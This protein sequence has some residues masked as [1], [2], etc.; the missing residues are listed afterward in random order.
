M[1]VGSSFS[2]SSPLALSHGPPAATPALPSP[3]SWGW[4][5]Y[6]PLNFSNHLP[7]TVLPY[8]LPST[9][10]TGREVVR[11]TGGRTVHNF[12]RMITMRTQ[13]NPY[14][15]LVAV[16]I[17]VVIVVGLVV[18][19]SLSDAPGGYQC[20]YCCHL[21]ILYTPVEFLWWEVYGVQSHSFYQ[22]INSWAC[23]CSIV[24]LSL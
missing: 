15:F 7:T 1:P 4:R 16:F 9:S 3:Q 14:E 13:H 23:C 18:N 20:C 19:K 12:T 22:N 2:C 24:E 21:W 6:R 8:T 17:I 10:D 5:D 11:T